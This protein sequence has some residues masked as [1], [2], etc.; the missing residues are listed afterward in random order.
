MIHV[1]NARNAHLYTDQLLEMH[2]W[3]RIQCIDKNGWRDLIEVEGGEYDDYDGPDAVYLLGLNPQGQVE[4]GMRCHPTE[5]RCMLA[6]KYPH[7]IAP[8]EAPKKGPD[9]WEISRLFTTDIYRGRKQG[10]GERVFEVYVAAMEVALA[11]GVDAAGRHARHGAVRQRLASPIE[12]RLVGLPQ[13]YAFGVMAGVEIPLSPPLLQQMREAIGAQA[14]VAYVADDI[15]V[16]A[17]GSVGGGGGDAG[18]GPQHPRERRNARDEG[19][20]RIE[21]LYREHDR[22][23]QLDEARAAG[24][25]GWLGRAS[26][27]DNRFA[28]PGMTS[29]WRVRRRRGPCRRGSAPAAGPGRGRGWASVGTARPA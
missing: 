19:I 23:V 27:P 2:R 10:R 21:Q 3:R 4:V 5:P 8:G 16:N 1:V 15:E 13:P 7:L 14:P 12:F 17:F 9:V 22:E 6:D 20:R 29:P 18:A 25:K 28:V 24:R 26:V 11:A